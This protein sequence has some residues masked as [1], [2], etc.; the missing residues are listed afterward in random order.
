M[1]WLE[2]AN[3]ETPCQ[4]EGAH[5]PHR[6]RCSDSD[7][8]CWLTLGGEEYSVLACCV[9]GQD[10]PCETKRNHKTNR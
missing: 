7:C 3:P 6:L 1:P 9:C 2:R 5:H 10:W 8:D 4:P